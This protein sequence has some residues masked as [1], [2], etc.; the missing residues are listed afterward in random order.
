MN[1]SHPTHLDELRN[2]LTDN[3]NSILNEIWRYWSE[4]NKIITA[5]ALYI[6]FGK[7]AVESSLQELGGSIVLRSG[8]AGRKYYQITFLGMLLTDAGR[9]SQQL[10]EQYLTYVHDRLALEPELGV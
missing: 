1:R 10:L 8:D 9:T 4:E 6:K 3:Q 7:K 5:I 2:R